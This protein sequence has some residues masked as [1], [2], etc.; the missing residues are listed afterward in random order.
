MSRR[1]ALFVRHPLVLEQLSRAVARVEFRAVACRW[2]EA[3]SRL[4]HL[5]IPRA[6]VYI[7]DAP[8]R[9]ADAECLVGKIIA[10]SPSARVL[11]VAEK[12]D[13]STSFAF[14]R[15]GAK[16]LL[17][18]AQVETQLGP[19]VEALATGGSWVSREYLVRFI[20][21]A[22]RKGLRP[23]RAAP[24]TLSRRENEVLSLLM[25]NLSNKEIAERLHISSRTAK[26]HV[27]NLLAKYGVKRRVDL[28]M[29]RTA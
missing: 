1:V 27:S 6:S 7:V 25:E 5:R 2:D 8:L 28:L 29:M 23:P 17:R 10:R 18:Y 26:F 20:D 4:G 11:V 14:L 19:A 12:I 3:A 21:Q 15:L 24:F 22:L 16:G 13:E 9:R